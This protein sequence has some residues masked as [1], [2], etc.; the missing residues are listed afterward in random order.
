M[1]KVLA[2]DARS[3]NNVGAEYIIMEKQNGIRLSDAWWKMREGAY[4]RRTY[5][6]KVTKSL[7]K[8]VRSWAQVAFPVF[9]GIYF[10]EQIDKPSTGLYY[11]DKFSEMVRDDERY[12]FGPS[13]SR[14]NNENGRMDIEF[15]RG[16]CS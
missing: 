16:P 9:G 4:F 14:L 10:K 15:D 5:R 2:Y 6:W 7:Q 3:A 8:L 1:P 12:V 11:S 13:S